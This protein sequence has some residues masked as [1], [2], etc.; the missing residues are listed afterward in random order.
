[1]TPIEAGLALRYGGE[2]GSVRQRRGL[3]S[4]LIW[5][6]ERSVRP[7]RKAD[8][9]RVSCLCVDSICDPTLITASGGHPEHSRHDSR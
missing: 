9:G 5:E 1:M 2:F 8:Y 3:G 6:R 4:G 7:V